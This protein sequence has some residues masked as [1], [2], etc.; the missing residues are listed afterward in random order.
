MKRE[1]T[2][3]RITKNRKRKRKPLPRKMKRSPD[4]SYMWTH[5]RLTDTFQQLHMSFSIRI[6]LMYAK[7]LHLYCVFTYIYSLLIKKDICD[8]RKVSVKL[9]VLTCAFHPEISSYFLC[10]FYLS[11]LLWWKT[12][13]FSEVISSYIRFKLIQ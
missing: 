5:G 6:D 7:W 13:I 10:F 8:G 11:L 9:P 4:E 2:E 3:I 1:S 12:N